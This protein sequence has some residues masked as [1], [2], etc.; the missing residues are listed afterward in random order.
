M[1]PTEAP[2]GSSQMVRMGWP[3]TRMRALYRAMEL[4]ASRRYCNTIGG[5]A[6]ILPPDTVRR[7]LE[8]RCRLG[9]VSMSFEGFPGSAVR[10]KLDHPVID[11][12]AHVV[13]C[14]F[15]H[16][17]LVREIAGAEVLKR[18]QAEKAAHGPTVR[19]FWWGLPSGP[20]TA[21]RAMAM[22]PRYFRS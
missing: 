2:S 16:Q 5:P 14:D 15:A 17:D 8:K 6:A 22:L 13:E 11:A 7:R 21:D 10:E 12:D 3:L 18:V 9:R 20:H 19:G 4:R 1:M